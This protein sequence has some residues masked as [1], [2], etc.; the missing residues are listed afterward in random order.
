MKAGWKIVKLNDVCDIVKGRKPNL[1]ATPNK[2]DLP[3]LVARYIRGLENPEY[4]SPVEKGVVTLTEADTVIICD[5]SNSGEI[6]TG[7]NGIMSSTMGKVV[8]KTEIYDPYL[9]HFLS[10]TFELFNGTKTG[11]AIPHLDKDAFRKLEIPLPP[12]AEQ[13]RIVALL[14]EAFAGIDEAKV[15]TE[16]SLQGA[17]CAYESYSDSIFSAQRPDWSVMR[18]GELC[19]FLNGFA[20]KSGDVVQKSQTQLVRMGNLY[21]NELDLNRSPVFYPNSFAKDYARYVLAEGDVIMSLTGTTGKRDYG[22]AVRIPSCQH[23]LLLNQRIMK[24][25]S[26]RQDSVDDT[27]FLHYLRSRCFLDILYP[28]AKGTRQANL[29]SVTMKSLP[30][31]IPPLK[32]QE[33]ISQKI[34]DMRA[35]SIRLSDLFMIKLG[36]LS[37]L[38][39]SLLAQAFAGELTA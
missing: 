19:E 27:Y 32:E 2:G 24:F 20:F 38:K 21:G 12:L 16:A 13:K 22:F 31:P 36:K 18:L 5:G 11:S 34:S 10:S 25:G 39:S 26:I 8:K 15:N 14:D 30:V 1:R 7:L 28:T 33:T 3:Y 17:K 4:G 29:S 6:F 35:E 23:A 9:R 37:E